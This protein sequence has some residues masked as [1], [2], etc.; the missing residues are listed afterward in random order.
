LFKKS[1]SDITPWLIYQNLF[2]QLTK[3]RE[4]RS[5]F[6]QQAQ[7]LRKH[8]VCSCVSVL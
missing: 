3:K 1:D 6:P 4:V 7:S 5:Q 8:A 2:F